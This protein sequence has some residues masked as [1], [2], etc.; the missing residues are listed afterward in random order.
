MAFQR[1]AP[2]RKR[3][4]SRFRSSGRSGL[5]VPAANRVW[6]R[7]SFTADANVS[8]DGA[9]NTVTATF[10]LAGTR[11]IG[12]AG[13]PPGLAM[14]QALRSVNVGGI[15]FGRIIH[16]TTQA[17][18]ADD[19][20]T[21]AFTICREHLVLD[22]LDDGG[23]AVAINPAYQRSQFPIAN[24]STAADS[25]APETEE[26]DYPMKVLWSNVFRSNLCV[27]HVTDLPE[28]DGAVL[29]NGAIRPNLGVL[30]KRLKVRIDDYHG[31]FYQ[32]SFITLPSFS[33]TANH[34]Y[35][36]AISGWLYYR[37]GF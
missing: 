11:A 2:F 24:A 37:L 1:R 6:Q 4:F 23:A 35:K 21:D 33:S 12:D 18:S 5:K 16:P 22:R 10:K 25:P 34:G 7:A 9:D 32:C 19:I 30:N 29:D 36:I 13:T 14:D 15:V 3:S 8:L 27:Y 28:G 17:W 31:L 20:P 26:V